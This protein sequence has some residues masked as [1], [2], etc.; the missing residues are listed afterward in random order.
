MLRRFFTALKEVVRRYFVAGI[1]LFAP[2]GITAWAIGSIIVWLDN[3]LL[4]RLIKL[5]VPGID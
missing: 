5:V 2:L 3:L 4:P 1:L